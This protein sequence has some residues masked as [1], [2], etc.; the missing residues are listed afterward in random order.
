M[1]AITPCDICAHEAALA[2]HPSDARISMPFFVV[3][4]DIDGYPAKLV[5]CENCMNKYPKRYLCICCRL[6]MLDEG[7]LIGSHRICT[8]CIGDMAT[9]PHYPHPEVQRW[10]D[11][12]GRAPY[13]NAVRDAIEF[14]MRYREEA[15]LDA[16]RAEL[17][18]K[19][20]LERRGL[21]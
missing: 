5:L 13:T 16:K 2:P 3:I 12:G 6:I 21:C 8:L 15:R 19:F 1:E 9:S 10:L 18:Y 4:N 17:M 14:Y 11:H 20:N 7:V